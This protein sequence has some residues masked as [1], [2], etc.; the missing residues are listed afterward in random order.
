MEWQKIETAPKTTG[1]VA[2]C[3]LGFCPEDGL[4]PESC[5]DVIWWEPNS[6]DAGHGG[7]WMNNA[8][9]CF[10]THWMP[11]PPAPETD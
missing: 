6:G 10:P 5:L 2:H 1:H 3:L 11:L 7:S 9:D 4:L 8:G